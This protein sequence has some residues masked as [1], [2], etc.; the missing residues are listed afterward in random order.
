MN[1]GQRNFPNTTHERLRKPFEHFNYSFIVCDKKCLRKRTPSKPLEEKYEKDVQ[2]GPRDCPD[3]GVLF[4]SAVTRNTSL[5]KYVA[6]VSTIFINWEIHSKENILICILLL[7]CVHLWSLRCFILPKQNMKSKSTLMFCYKAFLL[8]SFPWCVCHLMELKQNKLKV[9]GAFLSNASPWC[10][11][12][13]LEL[14][15]NKLKDSG[16]GNMSN[17]RNKI[18]PIHIL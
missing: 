9:N 12:H 6:L 3:G 18:Y 8:N 15:Q 13:V 14:K 7:L 16:E 4:T 1:R 11:C 10:F 5:Q 17:Y 2:S